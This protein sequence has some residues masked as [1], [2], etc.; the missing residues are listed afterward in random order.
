MVKSH[1]KLLGGKLFF[2]KESLLAHS[3]KLT[4]QT[5]ES[6]RKFQQQQR[7]FFSWRDGDECYLKMRRDEKLT[8]SNFTEARGGENIVT[9]HN[10]NRLTL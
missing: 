7:L 3:E 8:H 4:Q 9:A 10:R 5:F 6:R 2:A 1:N